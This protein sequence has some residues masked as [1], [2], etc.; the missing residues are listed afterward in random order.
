LIAWRDDSHEVIPNRPPQKPSTVRIREIPPSDRPREKLVARGATSLT[1]AELLAIFLRTGIKGKSAI[2]LA[3]ELLRAKG[4]LRAL[5]RCQATELS[6]TA[7]GMGPAKAA[8]LAAAFE[9]G[10]RLARGAEERPVLDSAEA[11]YTIF[12]A[13]FQARDRESL[14][15]VLLDTKLRLL[16]IEDVALGSLN[17]C[18]AHPREIFR[19]AIVHSAYAVILIHN[20]P[21]GDPVPSQAD[22]RLTRQLGEVAKLLQITFLDHIII[23]LPDGGRTP[24]FSFREA[25]VL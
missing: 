9:L 12:G 16:R 6:R 3:D 21:S 23:G 19:P 5:S 22:H 14:R 18:V 1:D 20:H 4:S 10:K 13:E 7:P 24:Y 25:G 2:T 8:E 15:I 11:V 17:E